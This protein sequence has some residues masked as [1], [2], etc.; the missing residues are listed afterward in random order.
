MSSTLA[1]C[2]ARSAPL[3]LFASRRGLAQAAWR[4]SWGR[5]LHASQTEKSP[6]VQWHQRGF[7]AASDSGSGAAD[8]ALAQ[9]MA[10]LRHGD[11]AK[12]QELLEEALRLGNEKGAAGLCD[13]GV[14][15]ED[16]GNEAKACEL[17]FK[18][19]VGGNAQAAY[20]AGVIY[21]RTGHM[22][23]AVKLWKKAYKGGLM[24][25][26]A[27]L[28]AFYMYENDH[29]RAVKYLEKARS[30]GERSAAGNLGNIYLQ[31][32]DEEKA[33][34]LFE[35]SYR[36]GNVPSAFNLGVIRSNQGRMQEA[37]ELFEEAHQYGIEAAAARLRRLATFYE[38]QGDQS[39]GRELRAKAEQP[40]RA[41]KFR[42]DI[43][44]GVPY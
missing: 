41:P 44:V 43:A 39:K 23:K 42:D 13:L 31:Q 14:M 16:Q 40:T 21:Q 29:A 24:A 17:Y 11:F 22:D 18:A 12:G 10:C 36:L 5:R 34:E 15:L 20:N 32:G 27:N 26:A 3:A 35:E 6:A 1:R 25:G 7:A 4:P 38:K 19:A 2:C 28:G 8:F 37:E 33:G 9:G 30:A